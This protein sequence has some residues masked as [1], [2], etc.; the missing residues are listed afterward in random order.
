MINELSINN[1]YELLIE[2]CLKA[3]RKVIDSL[4]AM[5]DDPNIDYLWDTAR[6]IS[7]NQHQNPSQHHLPGLEYVRKFMTHEKILKHIDSEFWGRLFNETNILSYVSSS[8]REEWTDQLYRSDVPEFNIDSVRPTI[9]SLIKDLPELF[10]QRLR[11]A[12]DVLSRSHKTNKVQRFGKRMI[13]SVFRSDKYLFLSHFYDRTCGAINDIRS[14]ISQLMGGDQ[15][16]AWETRELLYSIANKGIYGEWVRLNEYIA[17]KIFMK[18][19]C[20]LEIHPL[21]CDQLNILLSDNTIPD[22]SS[23]WYVKEQKKRKTDFHDLTN[24]VVSQDLMKAIKADKPNNDPFWDYIEHGTYNHKPVL[25][26]V[27][28][29]GFLPEYKS[30]QFYPTP[31]AIVDRMWDEIEKLNLSYNT[32]ILE[33]S[34]GTGRLLAYVDKDSVTAI[35]IAPLH[36]EILQA[37]GF[38]KT[39]NM[40]F[41]NYSESNKFDLIVMNP[42]FSKSRSKS[43]AEKARNHLNDNGIIFAILPK[44]AIKEDYKII[45]HFKGVFE[46]TNIDTYLVRIDK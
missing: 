24:I 12:H 22:L 45:E 35:D 2:E 3:K 30:H 17:V 1:R 10:A 31:K 32:T 15:F 46:N 4:T 39:H 11:D 43:H 18:G 13:F 41:M 40:D 20:H 23:E 21:I 29:T 42:P 9:T 19:T 14:T 7:L 5:F 26:Y 27:E 38:K 36:C 44:S 8:V 28:N 6:N 25:K 16:N 37:K 33:P 34:A